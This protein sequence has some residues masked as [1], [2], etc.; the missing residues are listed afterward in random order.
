MHSFLSG[1]SR[2]LILFSLAAVLACP[3]VSQSDRGEGPLNPAP[4]RGITPDEIVQ[5]FAAKEKQFAQAREQYTYKESVTVQTLEGDSADGE[6]RQSWDVNFD[7]EG[8]RTMQ[9]T[10]APMST[11]RRVQMT[12]E[13]LH[14]IQNLMPFVL[15]TDEIPEYNISYAGQQ[16][17]DELDTYVF[18]ISP[19]HIEKNKRY[20]EGRI[21]VDNRD[22]QI[23][24]TRGKSVPDIRNKG[25]E[26]LFPRF[27]TY[28]EQVDNVY[29]FPTYTRA[30]DELHFQ[31]GDVHI[32]VIVRYTNYKRF[33]SNS[34][35]VYNGQ[36]VQPG[37]KTPPQQQ[38]SGQSPPPSS[39]PQSSGSIPPY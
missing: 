28:R 10:Y 14:D 9:V 29:W 5:R 33:G 20:F 21:W 3:L 37:A 6:Y 2:T 38:P 23:V 11:L 36:T 39:V 15:T 18:D 24:M 4:P 35:I 22:F 8:H 17:E 26:N 7:N 30:D 16:R 32:R 19:R 34:R 1:F 25:N 13:D 31:S 27:T 12:A